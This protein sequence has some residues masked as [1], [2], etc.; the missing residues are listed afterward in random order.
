LFTSIGP[1]T[2]SLTVTLDNGCKATLTKELVVGVQPKASFDAANVCTG[3]PVVFENKT[4]WVQGDISYNWNFGDGSFTTDRAPRKEYNVSV[5][6]TYTVTL[7]ASIT[8]GCSDQVTKQITVNEGPKT[9]DFASETDYASSYFGMKM[10]AIDGAG[11]PLNQ[12]GVTYTWVL[13][14]G[15]NKSGAS[16]SHNFGKDGSYQVTMV[17]RVDATGCECTKTKVVTMN[18]SGVEELSQEGV[19][20]YPNPSNGVFQVL[21]TGDFGSDVTIEVMSVNGS[22]VKT[23]NAKNNGAL[24]IDASNM[25]DGVYELRVRSGT[26]VAT[27]KVIVRR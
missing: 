15:G 17:A 18:R 1:K 5:T 24:T 4:E 13:E 3:Q 26:R 7:V 16:I 2:A 12:P 19:T 27:R 22:V 8:N 20:I 21:L 14:G 6:T 11:Q 9:C 25:S 10:D 23:I